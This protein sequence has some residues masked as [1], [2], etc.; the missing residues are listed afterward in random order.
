MRAALWLWK[1]DIVQATRIA[2]ATG[3]VFAFLLMALGVVN[4]LAGYLIGGLWWILIGMFVRAAAVS[5]FRQQ[6]AQAALSERPVSLF[7]RSDPVTVAPDLTLDRLVE[8]YFYR[9]YFKSF[10]V[11]EHGRLV[12]CVSIDQIKAVDRSRWPQQSVRTVMEPCGPD[13]TVVEETPAARALGLMQRT[14]RSRLFVA[15]DD[16]LV[17]VLSLRDLLNYL[18]LMVDLEGEAAAS[19][20]RP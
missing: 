10:P 19:T 9:F 17:G 2:A 8:E 3:S 16:R 13:N 1:R 11:T 5:G 7:M 20:P 4:L 15:R 14:G 6:V 18:S 12:G